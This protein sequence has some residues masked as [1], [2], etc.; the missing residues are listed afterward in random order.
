MILLD[1]FATDCDPATYAM[2]AVDLAPLPD[3]ALPLVDSLL[4]QPIPLP[5][6]GE[7]YTLDT[8]TNAAIA[9]AVQRLRTWKLE[10][11]TATAAILLVTDG[12]PFSNTCGSD[13]DST[14]AEAERALAGGFPTFVL[15]VGESLDA[16]EQIA[17]A[18]GTSGAY[19]AE[20]EP[21]AVLEKLD[22]IRVRALP[23]V[24]PLSEIDRPYDLGELNVRFEPPGAESRFI[25]RVASDRECASD[26]G[27]QGGWY[28]DDPSSPVEVRLCEATCRAVRAQ[29]DA[30]LEFVIGCPVM[31]R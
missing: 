28:Y 1:P 17:L 19:L 2:P 4:A 29:G 6:G 18:G 7:P 23:C 10:N 24:L 11:P 9:G 30:R 27:V 5:I 21:H 22:A 25:P 13:L 31:M 26:G 3:N 16:L 20:D 15:G 8:P 12:E 14:T